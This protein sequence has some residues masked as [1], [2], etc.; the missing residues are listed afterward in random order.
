M[1]Q[2]E[3]LHVS[4]CASF[5]ECHLEVFISSG[6]ETNIFSDGYPNHLQPFSNCSWKINTDYESYLK[7]QI[8]DLNVCYN[9]I[10]CRSTCLHIDD[11]NICSR[12]PKKKEYLLQ[13][14]S[15]LITLNTTNEIGGRGFN[16]SIKAVGKLYR[17][18]DVVTCKRA[19][20]FKT[21]FISLRLKALYKK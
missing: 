6:N 16:L 9:P 13:N 17:V 21:K 20:C 8:H 2:L 5:S 15:T 10:G 12:S 7:V 4:S 1:R 18:L 19:G 14:N 11:K 3:A